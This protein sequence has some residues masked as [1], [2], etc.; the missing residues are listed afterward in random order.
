MIVLQFQATPEYGVLTG[1]A[2]MVPNSLMLANPVDLDNEVDMLAP[3]PDEVR[4]ELIVELHGDCFGERPC[5]HRDA[6]VPG[7]RSGGLGS[8][9]MVSVSGDPAFIEH[10]QEARTHPVHGAVE[11]YG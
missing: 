6:E 2:G 1:L 8:P 10:E 7:D 11:F 9:N 5:Q 4:P 3:T